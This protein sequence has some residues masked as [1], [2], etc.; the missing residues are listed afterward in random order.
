MRETVTFVLLPDQRHSAGLGFSLVQLLIC[1][2]IYPKYNNNVV[3]NVCLHSLFAEGVSTTTA[4]QWE[5]PWRGSLQRRMKIPATPPPHS[6]PPH[7]RSGSPMGRAAPLITRI[8]HLTAPLHP[9][10]YPVSL[11]TNYW[12]PPLFQIMQTFPYLS[13]FPSMF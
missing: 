5:A 6:L 2:G 3:K 13:I 1:L 7:P 8:S 11:Q 10:P 4:Q 12:L 9:P